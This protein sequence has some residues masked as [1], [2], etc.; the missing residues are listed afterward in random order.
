M[1]TQTFYNCIFQNYLGES[2]PI[3]VD[4]NCTLEELTHSFFKKSKRKFIR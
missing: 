3:K 1:E 4:D 2:I